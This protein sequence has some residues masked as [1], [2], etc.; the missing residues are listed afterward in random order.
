M[1][2][3]SILESKYLTFFFVEEMMG[4]L[5]SHETRLNLEEGSMQHAFK[6]QYFFSKGKGR[7]NIQT[8]QRG[9]GRGNQNVEDRH[10]KE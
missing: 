6:T 8:N 2:V 5:M 7:R 4:S 9:I 10:T 3:T 1:V